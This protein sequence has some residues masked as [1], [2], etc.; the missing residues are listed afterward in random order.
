MKRRQVANQP[1]SRRTSNFLGANARLNDPA[2]ALSGHWGDDAT[3]RW[4]S[5]AIA[6]HAAPSTAGAGWKSAAT[7]K[8]VDRTWR[9]DRDRPDRDR[10]DPRTLP[11]SIINHRNSLRYLVRLEAAGFARV[12]NLLNLR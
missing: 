8:T 9:P 7:D 3:G 4:D 2:A 1:T 5:S 10:P 11:C 12:G 6:D